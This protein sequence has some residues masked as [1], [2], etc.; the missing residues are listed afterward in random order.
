MP[1]FALM[2]PSAALARLAD[3][4]QLARPLKGET[5]LPSLDEVVAY[6]LDVLDVAALA[7][8]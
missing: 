7:A 8:A 3:P 5:S 4:L 1:A 2:Y 6:V